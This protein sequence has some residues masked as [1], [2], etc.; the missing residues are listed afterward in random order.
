MSES[1]GDKTTDPG[2]A[3][4]QAGAAKKGMSRRT[5]LGLL[6]GGLATLNVAFLAWRFGAFGRGRTVALSVDV[7]L[8]LEKRNF[9]TLPEVQSDKFVPMQVRIMKKRGRNALEV[10]YELKPGVQGTVKLEAQLLDQNGRVVKDLQ[11]SFFHDGKKQE[12][13]EVSVKPVGI[14][15]ANPKFSESFDVNEDDLQRT[16]KIKLLFSVS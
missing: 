10:V 3:V 5:V 2:G 14:V 9:I 8:K 12:P 4:P 15:G 11:K 16:D 13:Q 1:S 7:P 6:L